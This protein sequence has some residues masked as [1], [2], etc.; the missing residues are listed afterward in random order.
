MSGKLESR[1]KGDQFRMLDPASLPEKAVFPKAGMFLPLGALL[2]LFI[3]ILA[4]LV[5]EYLDETVKDT[6][7]LQA[8]Q[9]YPL[10]ASIPHLPDLDRPGPPRALIA[11]RAKPEDEARRRTAAELAWGP[12]QP[13]E[14]TIR[15]AGV[16]V[17]RK[18]VPIIETLNVSG[19]IVGEELRLF[20]SNLVD[21]CRRFGMNCIALDQRAS[22]GREEHGVPRPGQRAGPE[23]RP[24]GAARGCRPAAAVAGE[25]A[26]R[27][28]HRGAERVAQRDPRRRAG[29]GG[30]AGRLLLPRRRQERARAAGAAW[31]RRGWTR[32][33]KTARRL[34][35]LVL[36]DGVPVL[37]VADTVL[38]Q[39]LVDGFQ[40][41][42]RSR[43]TPRDA[44]RDTLAK[45]RPDKVIGVVFNDHR[46]YRASYRYTRYSRYA[47]A[48]GS[49]AGGRRADG[50]KART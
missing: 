49:E 11:A 30:G 22:G 9:G 29:G 33:L 5:A 39:D 28:A 25:D 7:V 43:T 23:G 12:R 41:V 8:I 10:L 42:V 18:G 38:M 50:S 44:I 31:G 17:S 15:H 3:G 4:S 37:P 16:V 48:G 35:D 21:A 34:F 19:S 40:L 6:E 27:A 26:R 13:G 14:V 1:W 32:C 47:A 36:L 20:G 24:P 46:E 45:L 2:G